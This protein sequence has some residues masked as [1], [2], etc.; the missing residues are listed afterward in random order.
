MFLS[1]AISSKESIARRTASRHKVAMHSVTR[2]GDPDP[3]ERDQKE[4][5]MRGET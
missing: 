4:S 1:A 5:S 3:L 2:G